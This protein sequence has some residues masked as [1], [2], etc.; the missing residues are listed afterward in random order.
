MKK[1][2]L[3]IALLIVVAMS[4]SAQVQKIA[5]VN[6]QEVLQKS[7]PGKAIMAEM[8]AFGQEKEKQGMAFQTEINTLKK[9]ISSPALNAD[10]REKKVATLAAKE[11]NFK[12]FM[13]DSQRE[14]QERQMKAMQKLQAEVMPI[15]EEIRKQK[16]LSIVFDLGSAGVTAFD[17]AID[18]TNDVVTAY[19]AKSAGKK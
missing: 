13:E 18:I 2:I 14:F 7:N 16:G 19:N 15:L 10:T 11:T 9:E 5:V 12:R 17:P 3:T 6:P 4:L 1:S 8:Q